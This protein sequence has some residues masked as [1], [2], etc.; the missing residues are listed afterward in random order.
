VIVTSLD[1][2]NFKP[3]CEELSGRRMRH[4]NQKI[5]FTT[6]QLALLPSFPDQP[7]EPRR[8][9][10]HARSEEDQHRSEQPHKKT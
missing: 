1:G 4:A 10:Q 9:P 7:E 3:V 8:R 5:P 6:T 2:V